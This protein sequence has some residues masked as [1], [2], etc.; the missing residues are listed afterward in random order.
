MELKRGQKIL[1]EKCVPHPRNYNTHP[2]S[3]VEKLRESIREFDQIPA[4]VVQAGP[5]AEWGVADDQF[6]IVK[7]HGF[8]MAMRE[9]GAEFIF[10]DIL[11]SDYPRDRVLAFVAVDNELARLALSDDAILSEIIADL[12]E[13]D[14]VLAE[15][16]AGTEE[17]LS[18]LLDLV[19]DA[20]A[21]D[22]E[23]TAGKLAEKWR[24]EAGQVWVFESRLLPGEFHR[25]IIGDCTDPGV[26]SRLFVDRVADSLITDPPFGVD[27][28]EKEEAMRTVL[29]R[30]N[31]RE[32]S[33]IKNDA[34]ANPREFFASFLSA[35]PL[36][37]YNTVYIF[38]AS[39]TLHD[40]LEAF[41][42]AGI[43]MSQVLTWVKNRRIIGRTDYQWQTE[44][45]V[46][47]GASLDPEESAWA[48]ELDGG[49]VAPVEVGDADFILY[50]WRKRHKFYAR[51][52]SRSTCL[53]YDA[54]P[55]S[56]YHPT[57]KPPG[58]LGQ[59]VT[60]CTKRGMVVY[61]CFAGSGSILL[62]AEPFGRLAYMAELDP[63]YAA[64]ILE[65]AAGL[66]LTPVLEEVSDAE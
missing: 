34:M 47:G 43:Y 40:L 16:A 65:R 53:F 8:A 22:T 20:E 29:K 46:Q 33:G 60:S 6:L 49:D 54:P 18:Q 19:T 56:P 42:D 66:G 23:D 5:Q 48:D 39:R 50:G 2:R 38:M 63:I 37:K 21:Y 13:T 57:Q 31:R 14:R 17:R 26:V 36:A 52:G 55:R 64:V 3:Q 11:P 10:A 7:G 32:R 30:K 58:L 4:I 1:L 44:F 25:L 27:Y 59:I 61:D 28:D 12:Y 35:A 45:I 15:L 24:T 41:N 9:E 62:A 51:R